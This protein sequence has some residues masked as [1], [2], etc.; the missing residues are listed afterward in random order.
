MAISFNSLGNL[1]RLGN[2]MFQYAFL[3]SIS[4]HQN[5][6]IKIPS[7]KKNENLLPLIFE[8]NDDIDFNVS[9]FER[10][11]NENNFNIVTFDSRILNYSFFCKDVYGYFQS[12]KYFDHIY[13]IVLNNFK[14]KDNIYEIVKKIISSNNLDLENIFF[15][16]IRG[17]DYLK[18][19]DYHFNLDESYYTKALKCFPK[20]R[21]CLVFTDDIE[22]IKNFRFLNNER[23]IFANQLFKSINNKYQSAYELCLMTLCNGGIISNS[24]F[25][26]WGA[27]LQNNHNNIV[28]PNKSYWFGYKYKFDA[29]DL[30]YPSWIQ[31]KPGL[32]SRIKYKFYSTFKF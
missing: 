30:I 23:F 24:S 29:S 18:K 15:L 4:N 25:S 10:F 26:W 22:Y 20:N 8:L 16:H 32:F 19:P 31:Y 21:K 14:F 2:Q 28:S 11:K 27:Y 13:K 1:G 9:S 7:Y 3:L 17:T 12:Y 5:Y 6:K